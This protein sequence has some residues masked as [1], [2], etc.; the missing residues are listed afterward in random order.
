MKDLAE[1]AD[2]IDEDQ[3]EGKPMDIFEDEDEGEGNTT[4]ENQVEVD[5]NQNEKP[6]LN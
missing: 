1:G 6:E 3:L 2:E 5:Q 4:D